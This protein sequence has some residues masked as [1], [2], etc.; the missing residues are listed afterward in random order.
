VTPLAA[1]AT[2]SLPIREL[3]RF[4]AVFVAVGDRLLV[5]ELVNEPAEVVLFPFSGEGVLVF[6]LNAEVL[7]FE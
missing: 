3:S 7:L 1:A 4:L 2:A 6:V 5:R